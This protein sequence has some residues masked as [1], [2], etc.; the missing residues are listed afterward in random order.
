MKTVLISS[1]VLATLAQ[2]LNFEATD[3]GVAQASIS[4]SGTT[5]GR[6]ISVGDANTCTKVDGETE[7]ISTTIRNMQT[8]IADLQANTACMPCSTPPTPAPVCSITG[9]TTTTVGGLLA[10]G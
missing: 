9:G 1:A 6:D 7:C 3:P 10:P 4:F 5:A 2:Q 8:A